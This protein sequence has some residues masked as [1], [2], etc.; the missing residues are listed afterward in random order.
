[1]RIGFQISILFGLLLRISTGVSAQAALKPPI[2]KITALNEFGQEE[3][4]TGVIVGRAAGELYIATAAHVVPLPDQIKIHFWEQAQTKASIVRTNTGLDIAIIKCSPSAELINTPSFALAKTAEKPLQSVIVIGHPS[5]NNWDINYN[6]NVKATEF[7]L[8]DRLFTLAPIG[9]TPGNSGGPVLTQQYELLG[10]VQ[11][12]DPVK[13]VCV[14]VATLLKACQAWEVPTNLLTGI[15]VEE[16][17]AAAGTEDFRYQIF[18]QEA[19]T[20]FAAGKWQQAK[21]AYQQ[22]NRL[23]PSAATQRKIEECDLEIAKDRL[24]TRY[25]EQATQAGKLETALRLYEQARQQRDTPEVRERIGF[26]KERLAKLDVQVPTTSSN[27]KAVERYT[28]PFAGEM[29]FVT[30]GHFMMGNGESGYS[31]EHFPP[32][33]VLL[34]DFYI[35]AKEIT[36]EQFYTF[37]QDLG[38]QNPRVNHYD[39]GE[40]VGVEYEG[41]IVAGYE[42]HFDSTKAKYPIRV[43]WTQ[44]T[45]Y[46]NWLSKKT[47]F[48]YYLPTEAQWE[49]AARGGTKAKET[50]Y[51]GS[52]DADEVSWN[53]YSDWTS[54]KNSAQIGGLKKP[55][56]LGLYD[57]SGNLWEWC[58]DVYAD[59]YYQACAREGVVSNPKGPLTTQVD[60]YHVIRGG[61]W[62]SM[63][64]YNSRRHGGILVYSRYYS[65]YRHGFRVVRE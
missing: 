19:N 37:L 40:K 16:E 49:Y 30:G 46:C 59:D 24:Y 62:E 18:V 8:D 7:E 12:V 13:A 39:Y 54:Y 26:I 65:Y 6:S 1:M 2:V 53:T 32:H 10:L 48:N 52:N 55:N 28:D 31:E 33:R 60:P 22:L 15:T 17:A 50:L 29:V 27:G 51:A 5:G 43:A 4:G 47:D 42:Y 25:F 63:P 3:D 45:A 38:K 23:S 56:E 44:A 35:G 64:Q 14:D 11:R 34:S 61:N 41:K 9:I 36:Y 21:E 57:M 20:A 58:R